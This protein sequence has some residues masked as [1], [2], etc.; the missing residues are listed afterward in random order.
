MK[1]QGQNLDSF[2]ATFKNLAKKAGYG[3]NDEATVDMFVKHLNRPLLDHIL[4]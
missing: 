3:K 1:M 4:D 2:I